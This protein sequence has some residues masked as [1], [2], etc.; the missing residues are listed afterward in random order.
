MFPKTISKHLSVGTP[1]TTQSPQ[2][3]IVPGVWAETVKRG[4]NKLDTE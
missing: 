1:S 2:E 3:F 4:K